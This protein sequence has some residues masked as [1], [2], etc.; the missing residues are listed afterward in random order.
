MYRTAASRSRLDT[1]VH[2]QVY[3]ISLFSHLA[4]VKYLNLYMMMMMLKMPML[5][6]MR[7]I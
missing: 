4:E 3:I 7:P 2:T 5:Q 1:L 6:Q